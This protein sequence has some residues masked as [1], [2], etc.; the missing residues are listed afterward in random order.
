M[1]MKKNNLLILAVAALCF[2]ACANDETTAVNEKLAESN[3]ISFRT[4]VSG[5]MRAADIT[6]ANLGEF[7][8]EAFFTGTTEN[9][10]FS[11]VTFTEDGGTFKSATKYY[12]PASKNLDFYAYSPISNTQ[13]D[14]TNYKTFVVTPST[15]IS[16]Q[17]D[18]IYACTKNW[19]KS[20]TDQ[21]TDHVIP[22]ATG[23]TINFRHAES[24]IVLKVKNSEPNLKFEVMG[25]KIVNVD[26]VG[27]F[28]YK[29]ANTDGQNTGEAVSGTT[30]ASGDWSGNI[31]PAER[32]AFYSTGDFSV[33]NIVPASQSSAEFL[34]HAATFVT[35][36][37]TTDEAI[38]MIL[39]P[40]STTAASAYSASAAGSAIT[41]ATGGSYIAVKMK[42]RNNDT[43]G[44]DGTG[45][46]NG[47]LIEDASQD[48]YWAIW[49]V[50]FNWAPGK[51]YT[52]TID[53]GGGGY[54]E[55]NKKGDEAL[56]PVLDGAVI[57]FVTVTV[58]E[59]D[60]NDVNVPAAPVVP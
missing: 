13:L 7:N 19:G 40:Q 9:P 2:A 51:K 24:K 54:W 42:I 60:N 15:T 48:G 32:T 22:T 34:N 33:N 29:D 46:G 17:V 58:D 55:K 23:V 10:Y 14:K 35:S 38:N 49:P 1:K 36:G 47:T 30:L 57:Q 50:A 53:L 5:Q 11:N 25:F 44:D 45:T 52:Y 4:L 16:G 28:T 8:A 59:W 31:D 27:T 56:D 21:T 39:V 37:S 3:E 20:T 26:G 43:K 41:T 18:L 12:W 6:N